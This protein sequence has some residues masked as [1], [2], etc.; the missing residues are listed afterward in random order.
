MPFTTR[1]ISENFRYILLQVFTKCCFRCTSAF[2][3]V[4]IRAFESV[5]CLN[6]IAGLLMEI[7]EVQQIHTK[8]GSRPIRFKYSQFD[9]HTNR[10]AYN[11]WI[12]EILTFMY[13]PRKLAPY[14]NIGS[15]I[16]LYRPNNPVIKSRVLNIKVC[17]ALAPI[18]K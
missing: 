16:S 3:R 17:S 12:Y 18:S 15:R 2:H 5:N 6:L 11:G 13:G 10:M 14:K 9:P 7:Y 1:S 4:L 8:T